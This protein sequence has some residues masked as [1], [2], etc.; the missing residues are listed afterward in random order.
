MGYKFYFFILLIVLIFSI[1]FVIAEEKTVDVSVNVVSSNNTINLES[2][3]ASL[4]SGLNSK[5]VNE[6]ST[7]NGFGSNL[8]KEINEMFSVKN[9]SSWLVPIIMIVI[10]MVF[11]ILYLALIKKKK[12]KIRRMK[13]KRH[14]K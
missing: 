14:K 11:I 2:N 13:R 5:V 8:N 12:K 6:S 1:S 4:D 9:N 7:I 3:P 10:V